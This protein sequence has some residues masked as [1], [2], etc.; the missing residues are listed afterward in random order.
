MKEIPM[1]SLSIAAGILVPIAS[2]VGIVT[3]ADNVDTRRAVAKCATTYYSAGAKGDEAF[4]RCMKSEFPNTFM[5]E[6]L[7]FSKIEE[8]SQT[9]E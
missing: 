1:A 7:K 9:S 4:V 3:V 2:L 6:S 8:F 5:K